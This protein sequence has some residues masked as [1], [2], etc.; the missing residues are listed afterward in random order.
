MSPSNDKYEFV[1]LK[2]DLQ[3]INEEYSQNYPAELV[4]QKIFDVTFQMSE[5]LSFV[6]R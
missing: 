4:Y 2:R 5:L 6:N 3:G 1:D